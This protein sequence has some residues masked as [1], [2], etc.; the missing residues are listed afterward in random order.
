MKLIETIPERLPI[1]LSIDHDLKQ[2][3]PKAL[4][5]AN[6]LEAE[7]NF[8]A[9]LANWYEKEEEIVEIEILYLTTTS[10]DFNLQQLAGRESHIVSD[11]VCYIFES[12]KHINIYISITDNESIKIKEQIKLLNALLKVKA[13]KVLS[14]IAKE[15]GKNTL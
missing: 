3:F 2:I 8:H 14:I 5:Y 4:A 6:K 10:Y 12:E 7:F 11:D 9:M 13:Q 15:L 1:T